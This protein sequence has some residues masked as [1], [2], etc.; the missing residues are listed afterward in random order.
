MV[1]EQ[2][3]TPRIHPV[4]RN[5]A[6]LKYDILT[7]LGAHGCSGDK[8]RQRLVLR[9]ITLVVARYNWQNDLL[10]VG[11][12][13]IA[14]LWSVDERTVKRDMAKLRDLG[15]LVIRRAAVRGRVAEYGLDLTVILGATRDDWDRVGSDFTARMSAPQPAEPSNVITFP[16]APRPEEAGDWADVLRILHRERPDLYAT[17]F[18]PL[19]AQQEAGHWQVTAP[20]RFHASFIASHH[21]QYVEGALRRVVSGVVSV[22]FTS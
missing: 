16:A 11:Q 8:H 3:Q 5:A 21:A 2:K 4:G 7:A 12:R 10:S 6:S 13:E 15:W 17:W 22:H 18:A 9:L 19:T 14:A 20:S 1:R